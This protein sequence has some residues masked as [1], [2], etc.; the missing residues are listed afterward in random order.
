MSQLIH[1]LGPVETSCFCRAE[2]NSGIK[3]DKRRASGV[4]LICGTMDRG[5]PEPAEP[6]E[7]AEPKK[8]I[9]YFDLNKY[10]LP[11]FKP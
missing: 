3:F 5:T 7:P 2:L 9:T 11:H 10:F 4:S 8:K 1:A 6:G